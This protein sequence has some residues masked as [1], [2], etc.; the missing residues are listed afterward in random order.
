[1][2]MNDWPWDFFINL[3]AADYPIRYNEYFNNVHVLFLKEICIEGYK[4]WHVHAVLQEAEVRGAVSSVLQ[5]KTPLGEAGVWQPCFSQGDN[6]L[7]VLHVSATYL[8]GTAAVSRLAALVLHFTEEA[9]A[10][11]FSRYFQ[12]G[13][14]AREDE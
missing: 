5:Q 11:L 4:G 10:A 2:E 7:T 9:G 6:H 13:A 1:M 3:S 12:Q 8:G 14:S